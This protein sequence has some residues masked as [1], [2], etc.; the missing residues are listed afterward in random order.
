MASFASSD[1]TTHGTLLRSKEETQ[2]KRQR[3]AS[4]SRPGPAAAVSRDEESPTRQSK[5]DTAAQ[6]TPKTITTE[7]G[8]GKNGIDD[9]PYGLHDQAIEWLKEEQ[10]LLCQKSS[11]K[12]NDDDEQQY[13]PYVSMDGQVDAY[14]LEKSAVEYELRETDPSK[15]LRPVLV[16][17]GVSREW[18]PDESH[19][20]AR[21]LLFPKIGSEDRR[22]FGALFLTYMPGPRH[23]AVDGCFMDDFGAWKRSERIL[24]QSLTSGVSSGGKYFS[25]PD[26]RVY[27]VQS[28]KDPNGNDADCGNANKT[29]SRFI[30]EVEY[31]NRDPVGLRQHG[32]KM[33][34]SIYT[35]LFLGAKFSDFDDD[36]RFEAAMVLWGRPDGHTNGDNISVV[37]AV[38]FGT[39]DLTE[40]TKTE[41]SEHKTGRLIGVP[42]DRWR[43]PTGADVA[44]MELPDEETSDEW[45]LTVPHRG[46]L[47]KVGAKETD[48]HGQLQY[49]L[50]VLREGQI[51]DLRINLQVM[52]FEFQNQKD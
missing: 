42:A 43:R 11:N 29:F 18:R 47:Y 46:I 41:F 30:W 12:N 32:H 6:Q 38:S 49:L 16:A 2:Q 37:D 27:P 17:V 8:G 35:R 4:E 14:Q 24:G 48:N 19:S 1:S 5:T 44:L 26:R 25:Q 15:R 50:D 22:S 39:K 52:A 34:R 20:K 31:G 7:A 28:R 21:F 40:K 51:R 45:F 9:N 3:L 23:G 10:K 33:M 36:G 13:Q